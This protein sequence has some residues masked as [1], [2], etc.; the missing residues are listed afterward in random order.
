MR[1]DTHLIK[2]MA[3]D[4]DRIALLMVLIME[5]I[6]LTKL[7]EMCTS[8]HAFYCILA[9]TQYKITKLIFPFSQKGEMPSDFVGLKTNLSVEPYLT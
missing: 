4:T 3:G 2:T 5:V 7:V 1:N 8:N 9:I 6:D